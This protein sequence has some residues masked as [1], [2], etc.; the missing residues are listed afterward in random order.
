M[1]LFVNMTEIDSRINKRLDEKIR[2]ERTILREGIE[3]NKAELE[4]LREDIFYEIKMLKQNA[5]EADKR[6]EESYDAFSETALP[7]SETVQAL[8]QKLEEYGEKLQECMQ[9]FEQIESKVMELTDPEQLSEEAYQYVK[10]SIEDNNAKLLGRVQTNMKNEIERNNTWIRQWLE[11]Q[12]EKQQEKVEKCLEQQPQAPNVNITLLMHEVQ[13]AV[14]R[15]IKEQIGSMIAESAEAQKLKQ[16]EEELNEQKKRQEEL[17]RSNEDE[18]IARAATGSSGMGRTAGKSGIVGNIVGNIVGIEEKKTEQEPED[19]QMTPVFNADH[20]HNKYALEQFVLQCTKLK[21]NYEAQLGRK[22]STQQYFEMVEKCQGQFEAMLRSMQE[23]NMTPAQLASQ[24]V[25]ILRQTLIRSMSQ[26][27]V[28]S[29]VEVFLWNC[30]VRKIEW[31]QGRK[32]SQQDGDY[33]D[34]HHVSYQKTKDMRIDRCIARIEQ[35][36]YA[37]DFEQEGEMYEVIIPGIY[38]IWKY[39]Q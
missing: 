10:N 31:E 18:K 1:P 23:K 5:E 25:K 38:K 17:I 35:D 7:V 29:M 14:E 12:N 8:E 24:T 2:V 22:E 16:L 30:S 39:E 15:N 33:V 11:E 37:V 19:T 3:N 32:L 13:A 34:T 20:A 6:M 27:T 28:K 36:A 21:E 9:R 4:R 26:K